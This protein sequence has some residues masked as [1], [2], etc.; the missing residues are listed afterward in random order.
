MSSSKPN[1]ANPVV[2]RWVDEMAR[3]C[4]PDRIFW[5]DGSAA[6]KKLLTEEAVAQG[7]LIQLNQ[8]KLPGCYYHRSDV[9]DVAR[10]EDRTFICTDNRRGGG[11]DQ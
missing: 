4:Q 10:S 1:T 3:L 2:V 5:C 6:E 11:A 7:V 8:Q 9:A